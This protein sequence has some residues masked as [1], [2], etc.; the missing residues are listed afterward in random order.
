MD[1]TKDK[2]V[3]GTEQHGWEI[4]VGA[5]DCFADVHGMQLHFVRCGEGRPLVLI[6]GL[7]GSTANWRRNVSALARQATVYAV[8]LA[9]MGR[10]DRRDGLD[11][12]LSATA[13]RI[14]EW[15][16]SVGIAKADIAGHSHGGAVAMMLAARHPERV[17]SLVL[18]AP[19]NPYSRSSDWMIRFYS[20]A[21]GRLVARIGLRMPRRVHL[22]MLGRMYG[23]PKRIV[24]GTLEGYMRGLRVPGTVQHVFGI[25]RRWFAEMRAL[26]AS[27]PQ[28]A[29]VPT[30]L[31]WGD[32]DR[33]VSLESGERLH[34]TL[35]RSEWLV[36]SGAGHVPFEEMPEACNRAM[37]RWLKRLELPNYEA[38]AVGVRK[39]FR[40]PA[41]GGFAVSSPGLQQA[42]GQA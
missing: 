16:Q 30:L 25:V 29:D 9:N 6:H 41:G 8:D 35:G 17:R 11:S 39:T 12:S 38:Q 24:P 18:F 22:V 19:A 2:V 21:P 34:R 13:D 23:D 40:E 28:L 33:A 14:A 7:V 10:S 42:S 5:E 32:R 26:E 37:L 20:T 3:D 31:V 36:I 1:V 15:M 27:L 4:A